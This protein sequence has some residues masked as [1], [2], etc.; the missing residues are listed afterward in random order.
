MARKAIRII[1]EGK[2]QHVGFRY[3]LLKQSQALGVV[4]HA[5]N[6]HDGSLEVEVA[7]E[8]EAL[9]AFVEACVEGP[10]HARVDKV[11]KQPIPDSDWSSFEIR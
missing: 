10:T 8:E 1:I 2:V 11:S 3:F 4:G 7:G 6:L 9:N 5:V